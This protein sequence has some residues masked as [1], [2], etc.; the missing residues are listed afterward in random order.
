MTPP[1]SPLFLERSSYRRRRILDAARLL[2]L[3]GV[4]LFALPLLWVKP[5]AVGH[6][7]AAVPTSSALLYIFS[8]WAGLI[9]L[10]FLFDLAARGWG[11]RA[12]APPR[13]D[14]TSGT[15]P[16]ESG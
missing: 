16:R 7:T 3:L 2:P 13:A 4:A 6:A 1:R 12:P 5:D 11:A 15:G 9:L 14:G 8:V 10:A